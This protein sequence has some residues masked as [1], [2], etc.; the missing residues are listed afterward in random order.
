[1]QIGF[2][3]LASYFQYYYLGRKI[4]GCKTSKTID[5]V[6]RTQKPNAF[7]RFMP[8]GTVKW[9]NQVKGFGFIEQEGG[10]DLFVHISQ[11]EGE[12]T[13]GDTVEFEI[14]EG[15]KGPNAVS[16]RKVE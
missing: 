5:F 15:P 13:D 3:F 8:Q 9:F 6:Q 1:M 16:V 14:G 2:D 10:D 4:N 11:V 12:I 7:H